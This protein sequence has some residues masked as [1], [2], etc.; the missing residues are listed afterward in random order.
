MPRSPRIS[1]GLYKEVGMPSKLTALVAS[2]SLLVVLN[3]CGFRLRGNVE[4]PPVLQ[5]TYIQSQAPFTGMAR[6]LRTQLERS[7]ANVLETKEQASAILTVVAERSENRVL[8]VGSRGKVTE[9]ELFDEATF[10]LSDASGKVLIKPQTVRITRDLVFDPNELLG[11]LSEAESY[12]LE[13]RG[14][15]ARQI[16]MRINAGMR[17]Q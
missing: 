11:K 13:M 10:S 14:N 7:G 2:L 1:A 4:L 17:H 3:A 8:S 16:L 6:A 5:D 12:H 15:L 9:Y